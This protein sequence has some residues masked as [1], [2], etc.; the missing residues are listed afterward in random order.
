MIDGLTVEEVKA[1]MEKMG[2]WQV[3]FLFKNIVVGSTT[4]FIF[5]KSIDFFRV[6]WYN[7]IKKR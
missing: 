6:L 4:T 5:S 7:K 2:L 1:F 3:L